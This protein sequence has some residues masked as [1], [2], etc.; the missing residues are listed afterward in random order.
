MLTVYKSLKLRLLVKSCKTQQHDVNRCEFQEE[1][2]RSNN[3]E[4]LE[5]WT[6]VT[7]K[8]L[9]QDLTGNMLVC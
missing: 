3:P 9:H 2:L 4:D 8:T 1:E 6:E 7:V 5:A